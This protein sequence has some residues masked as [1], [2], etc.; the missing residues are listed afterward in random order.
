MWIVLLPAI[1]VSNTS[2]GIGLIE[3]TEPSDTLNCK[4]IFKSC[5]FKPI[6][7]TYNLYNLS[8][9]AIKTTSRKSLPL[10]IFDTAKYIR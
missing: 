1:T 7:Y 5:I 10:Y 2:V 9:K 6:S 4:P 8:R 3:H